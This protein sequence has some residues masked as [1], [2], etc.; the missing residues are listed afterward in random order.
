MNDT[1]VQ[2]HR[3]TLILVFGILG[4]VTCFVFGIVA[5]IMGKGDLDKMAD[6]TMDPSGESLTKAG[7]ILGIV[8]AC[9]NL[10]FFLMAAMLVLGAGGMIATQ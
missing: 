8:A 5:W 2:P 7:V 3:G 4:L 1:T 9:L 6:G 10:I